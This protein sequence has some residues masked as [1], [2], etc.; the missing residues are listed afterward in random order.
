MRAILI[1]AISDYSRPESY[2]ERDQLREWFAS[3][4][5]EYVFSFASIIGYLFPGMEKDC[6]EMIRRSVWDIKPIVRKGTE[7]KDSEQI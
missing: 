2:Y 7:E 5:D 3:D 1:R 4:D 6:R